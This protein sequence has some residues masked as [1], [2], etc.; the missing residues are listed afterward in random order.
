[1]PF[2]EFDRGR[3]V[4]FDAALRHIETHCDFYEMT[5][6]GRNPRQHVDSQGVVFIYC[7]NIANVWQSCWSEAYST[8]RMLMQMQSNA[9]NASDG[10]GRISVMGSIG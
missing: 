5:S 8:Y 7:D 6:E 4:A 1:M 3:Y 9:R 2:T 10:S